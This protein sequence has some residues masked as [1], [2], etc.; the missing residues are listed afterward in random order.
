MT[1]TSNRRLRPGRPG[2]RERADRLRRRVTDIPADVEDWFAE[3]SPYGPT[4]ARELARAELT[5][6]RDGYVIRWVRPWVCQLL[7]PDGA[8]V[9]SE[10]D[11]GTSIPLPAP[12]PAR[13]PPTWLL[14]GASNREPL[15]L[16]VRVR[17][18]RPRRAR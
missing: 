6:K 9:I 13:S 3:H 14:K 8:T 15:P 4:M 2:D 7:E 17:D 5:A 11:G 1:T 18:R 12:S 10:S 16:L